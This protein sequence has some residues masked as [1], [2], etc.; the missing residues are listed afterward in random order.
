MFRKFSSLLSC[1]CPVSLKPSWTS[2]PSTGIVSLLMASIGLC[3]EISPELP[4]LNKASGSLTDRIGD[5]DDRNSLTETSAKL[6][7]ICNTLS[8]YLVFPRLV[9]Q[10]AI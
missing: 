8:R 1:P 2:D 10:V 9:H 7:M 4:A 3:Q 5:R 6:G